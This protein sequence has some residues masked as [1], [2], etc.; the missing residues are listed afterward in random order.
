M[1]SSFSFFGFT[2][3]G[4]TSK[5]SL[6]GFVDY[7]QIR[8]LFEREINTNSKGESANAHGFLYKPNYKLI[9]V[10]GSKRNLKNGLFTLIDIEASHSDHIMGFRIVEDQT[11]IDYLFIP[12]IHCKLSDQSGLELLGALEDLFKSLN[13]FGSLENYKKDSADS[14]FK[15]E[16]HS[17]RP[18]MG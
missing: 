15:L 9:N 7:P 13:E 14:P 2:Y 6:Y 12:K 11:G 18:L 5:A 10:D 17:H 4:F 3:S 16:S 1:T 8:Y